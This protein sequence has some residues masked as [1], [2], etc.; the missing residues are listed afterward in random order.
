M[1][2]IKLHKHV[3]IFLHKCQ[4]DESTASV[5]RLQ[6]L[7]LSLRDNVM[8][9]AVSMADDAGKLWSIEDILIVVLQAVND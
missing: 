7:K 2:A 8:N 5:L 9:E 1:V 6:Y 3:G 4:V